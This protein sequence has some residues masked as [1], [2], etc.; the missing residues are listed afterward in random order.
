MSLEKI[1]AAL[2]EEAK[3]QVAAIE[4]AAQAEIARIEEQ[5]QAAAAAEREKQCRAIREPLQAEQ[6]RILNRARQEAL[7]TIL[8]AR[9]AL[10][11][12]ALE[13]TARRLARL[14]DSEA[15]PPILQQLICEAAEAL[16]RDGTLHLR[17]RTRDVPLAERQVAALGL[18]AS[19]EGGLEDEASPWGCLGG[20]EASTADG[21]I[22]LVNTLAARL[23]RAADLY[24]S[25]IAE[26]LFGAGQER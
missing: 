10:I 5:A 25:H 6:A 13:G 1:L 8:G 23:A 7:Q 2:Q 24:R 20:V 26:L 4:Q 11:A 3:R 17:V 18:A 14:A 9:E 21:R 12:A 15:Y 16:G 22:R 19:V